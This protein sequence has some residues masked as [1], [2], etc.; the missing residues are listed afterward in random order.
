MESIP[1]QGTDSSRHYIVGLQVRES[2]IRQK[3]ARMRRR[4]RPNPKWDT[5]EFWIAVGKQVL[6]ANARPD[7]YVAAQFE[8]DR[9]SQGPYY[10]VLRG[11][12]A[13]WRY[14]QYLESRRSVDDAPC[15]QEI[16]AGRIDKLCRLAVESSVRHFPD[17]PFV[18]GLRSPFVDVP[19][20]LRL[21]L[22]PFDEAVVAR[23]G[24]EGVAE[25]ERNPVLQNQCSAAG[26]PVARVLGLHVVPPD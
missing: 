21:L 20:W 15:S 19:S 11:K 8:S 18:V 26:L 7:F 1:E 22:A 9:S 13:V 25:L 4:Y 5:V 16:D 23:F 12:K 10:T 14:R 6:G 2:Y 17:A 3:T 24:Y